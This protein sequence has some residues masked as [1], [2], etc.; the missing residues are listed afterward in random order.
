[1]FQNY[2]VGALV[3]YAA[4]AIDLA[5]ESLAQTDSTLETERTNWPD[6]NCCWLFPEQDWQG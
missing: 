4:S 3:A 2:V 1:M 5:N 6:P